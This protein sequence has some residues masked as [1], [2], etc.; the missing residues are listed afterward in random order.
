ME[1]VKKKIMKKWIHTIWVL[2]FLYKMGTL[3]DLLDP[4]IK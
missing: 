1:R 4:N 3:L 2:S